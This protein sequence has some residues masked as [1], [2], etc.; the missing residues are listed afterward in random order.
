MLIQHETTFSLDVV[1][2]I[3]LESL[4]F[5]TS[6]ISVTE[7]RYLVLSI[8]LYLHIFAHILVL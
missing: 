8:K 2:S 4:F 3:A 7:N 5:F 6:T 1:Y